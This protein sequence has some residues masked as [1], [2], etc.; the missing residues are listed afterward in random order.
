MFI[1]MD[2]FT[3]DMISKF[4]EQSEKI[5]PSVI[6][7]YLSV[8]NDLINKFNHVI[9][10]DISVY[11]SISRYSI[12]Y[13]KNEQIFLTTYKPNEKEAANQ[14][15]RNVKKEV[16]EKNTSIQAEKTIKRHKERI[17]QGKID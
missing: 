12:K 14:N 2:E 8:Q 1:N 16:D 10:G 3:F 15:M 13:K 7:S 6:T 4:F 9:E 17:K 5:E 11:K